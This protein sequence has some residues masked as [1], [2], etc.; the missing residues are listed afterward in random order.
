[1]DLVP[2]VTGLGEMI[3]G[4]KTVGRVTDTVQ[5]AKAAECSTNAIGVV[6]NAKRIHGNSLKTTKETVGYAL[7][8]TDTGEIMKFGETT[9][10]VKRYTNKFYIENGVYMD[11]MAR[12]SKYDMHLWQHDQIIEYT[13]K[14]GTRPPWNK[15]NW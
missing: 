6:K 4:A 9:R 2:I 10:G 15:T 8:K 7:R 11:I 12:G 13:Q 3:R 5:I 14:R 1:M